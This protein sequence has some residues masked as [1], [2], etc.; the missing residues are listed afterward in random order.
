MASDTTI[1]NVKAGQTMQNLPSL[2]VRTLNCDG[3]LNPGTHSTVTWSSLGEEAATASL[4]V[5][6]DQLVVEYR[7]QAPD[8]LTQPLRQ[9]IALTYTSPHFGGR[10]TW[11]LCPG[12]G[13]RC[14]KVFFLGEF[15]CRECHGLH[16]QSQREDLSMRLARRSDA[17][18]RRLDGIV[19]GGELISRRPR[20]MH[21]R[22]YRWLVAEH[23]ILQAA[24]SKEMS[25]K[26]VDSEFA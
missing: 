4:T 2:D 14:A 22:T 12:C 3:V 7:E 8:G 11:F 10:R 20:R 5:G 24:I 6:A 18:R 26:F 15:R 23:R 13:R 21:R 25:T 17:I 1:A 16:Y 19:V 9:T